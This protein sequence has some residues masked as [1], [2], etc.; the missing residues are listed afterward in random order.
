MK[1]EKHSQTQVDMEYGEEETSFSTPITKKNLATVG[2]RSKRINIPK[3]LIVLFVI[4]TTGWLVIITYKMYGQ[5]DL[6]GHHD[7][8]IAVLHS[9]NTEHPDKQLEKEILK[10]EDQPQLVFKTKQQWKTIG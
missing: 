9:D 5:N 1:E 6:C 3:V 4:I 10:E 7:D 8:H 2:H